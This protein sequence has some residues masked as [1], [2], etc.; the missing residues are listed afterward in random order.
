MECA[1]VVVC[2]VV[3]VVVSVVVGTVVLVVDWVVVVVLVVVVTGF[4]SAGDKTIG[5]KESVFNFFFLIS[6]IDQQMNRQTRTY[7][8]TG[9]ARL[10][11]TPWHSC[12]GTTCPCLPVLP[13]PQPPNKYW[14][15]SGGGRV[16]NMA[17][18]YNPLPHTGTDTTIVS[19]Q[20]WAKFV[21]YKKN[22]RIF[23][24]H[25]NQWSLSLEM[26]KR[27]QTLKCDSF[28]LLFKFCVCFSL[29][30]LQLSN[31]IYCNSLICFHVFNIHCF[32]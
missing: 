5:V 20:N 8:D 30:F 9:S 10:G 24:A 22:P 19:S 11:S 3:V 18:H 14:R 2:S 12:S 16:R 4:T 21:F 13:M 17:D 27:T 15:I 32:V 7:P 25:I 23:R 29:Y 26:V 28:T 6:W 31:V 1:C